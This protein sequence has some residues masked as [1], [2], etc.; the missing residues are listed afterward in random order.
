MRRPVLCQ[1]APSVR[2]RLQA[3]PF[4]AWLT[5]AIL[6]GLML[7]PVALRLYAWWFGLV[8]GQSLMPMR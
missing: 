5:L 2:R 8:M 1:N 3:L 7:L 4:W 6:T